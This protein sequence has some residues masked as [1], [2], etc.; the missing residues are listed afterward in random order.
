[1][2]SYVAHDL[3]LDGSGASKSSQEVGTLVIGAFRRMAMRLATPVKSTPWRARTSGDAHRRSV[4][5]QLAVPVG[6]AV[7]S[8]PLQRCTSRRLRPVVA[9]KARHC[10]SGAALGELYKAFQAS[11]PKLPTQPPGSKAKL[12]RAATVLG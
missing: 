3:I 7:A 8:R 12:N 1:M 11:R 5:R 4:G 10:M 2:P 6:L 9:M